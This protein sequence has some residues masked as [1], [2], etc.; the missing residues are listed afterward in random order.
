MENASSASRNGMKSEGCLK[1]SDFLI[2]T[3]IGSDFWKVIEHSLFGGIAQSGQNPNICFNPCL[4][5][6]MRTLCKVSFA[7][8]TLIESRIFVFDSFFCFL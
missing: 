7:L 6:S 3:K 4:P 2:K 8:R 5:P 1:I